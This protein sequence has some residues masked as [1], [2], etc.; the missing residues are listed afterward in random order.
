MTP[1]CPF[2]AARDK[3]R[4]ESPFHVGSRRESRV[5]SATTVKT[6]SACSIRG[7]QSRLGPVPI[8]DPA[9]AA[10]VI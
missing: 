5:A 2:L 8:P 1:T 6:W 10:T 4:Q 3:Q 9:L 7:R